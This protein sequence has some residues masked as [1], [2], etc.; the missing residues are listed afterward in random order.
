M[1]KLYVLSGCPANGKSTWAK[2]FT[3]GK[4]D[5]IIVSKDA[6]R[7]ARGEYWIP[8]QENFIREQAAVSV[9]IALEMGYNVIVDETNLTIPKKLLWYNIAKEY[10]AEV[11]SKI[12]YIPFWKAVIRNRNKNRQHVLPYRVLESFY[13]SFFP[14]RFKA[15]KAKYNVIQKLILKIFKIVYK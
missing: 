10:N 7:Y 3:K 5:W 13:E 2:K 4:K 9:R 1:S 11:V 8:E 15:E 12:F 14:K 6:L